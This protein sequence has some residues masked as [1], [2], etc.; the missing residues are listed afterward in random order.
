MEQY[1]IEKKAFQGVRFVDEVWKLKKKQLTKMSNAME[2][3]KMRQKEMRKEL[4]KWKKP[5]GIG[6]K[7]S[8]LEA[9]RFETTMLIHFPPQFQADPGIKLK[10]RVKRIQ[11][12]STMSYGEKEREILK[13]QQPSGRTLAYERSLFEAAIQYGS[14]TNVDNYDE[15]DP[16]FDKALKALTVKQVNELYKVN[17]DIVERGYQIRDYGGSADDVEKALEHL[18]RGFWPAT[19]VDDLQ[20][21]R[22]VERELVYEKITEL[23]TEAQKF[24]SAENMDTLVN[25][26]GDVGEVLG[27]AA[28]AV[29]RGFS[30][31]EGVA[32]ST[33][34]ESSKL[35]LLSLVTFK[36][37]CAEAP[38]DIA[39]ALKG[40][41]KK[42]LAT[43]V[44]EMT[45]FTASLQGV[46]SL[47]DLTPAGKAF[48][49]LCPILGAIGA[50]MELSLVAVEAVKVAKKRKVA[51]DDLR[52]LKRLNSNLRIR[53]DKAMENALGNDVSGRDL[54]LASNIVKTISKGVA[55]AGNVSTATGGAGLGVTAKCIGMGNT[56]AFS[57]IDST[58]AKKAMKTLDQARA[59]STK[60]QVKIFRDSAT[61]AKMYMAMKAKDGD[62]FAIQ[63]IENR[64]L[65]QEDLDRPEMSLRIIRQA[66]MDDAGQKDE[67]GRANLAMNVATD[68]LGE[69]TIN[70]MK[71]MKSVVHD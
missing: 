69:G 65:T 53:P 36:D 50:G 54:Q 37:A 1:P 58:T 52:T 45:K 4:A 46:V 5:K 3:A 68:F 49:D 56:L 20:A 28:P 35:F 13:L 18:P 34:I 70:M 22:H 19:L 17:K 27:G 21:W 7:K 40:M 31:T 2:A 12:A 67:A 38:G 32:V 10:T 66:L 43:L 63:L 62:K 42:D 47:G 11:K 71:K 59:G 64:G 24:F 60:A 44:T 26:I 33:T 9:R 30:T 16:F 25:T 8:H 48:V 57:C 55:L 15:I 61:Y 41:K 51:V 6:A 39:K 29:A 14:N 23:E